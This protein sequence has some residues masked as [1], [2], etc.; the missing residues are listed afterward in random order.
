MHTLVKWPTRNN[1]NTQITQGEVGKHENTHA[2]HPSQKLLPFKS[3]KWGTQVIYLFYI[4]NYSL[5][6]QEYNG[7][8]FAESSWGG[9]V[10]IKDLQKERR[11]TEDSLVF[12]LG[13]IVAVEAAAQARRVVAQTTTGAIT[14]RLVTITL[15]HIRTGGALN[16]EEEKRIMGR[17]RKKKRKEVGWCKSS[18]SLHNEQS[19]PR[20]PRSHTHPTCFWASQGVS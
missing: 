1:M 17:V 14:A 11:L 13:A 9:Q 2:F 20:L 5:S 10:D 3:H 8:L 19:G 12:A 18:L 15:E 6:Y 16:C 7:V 4:S